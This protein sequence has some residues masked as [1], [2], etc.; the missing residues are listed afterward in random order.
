M[1]KQLNFNDY[2]NCAAITSQNSLSGNAN[3]F[4]S[5]K[6]RF[7]SFAFFGFS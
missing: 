1:S 7:A 5:M 6:F 2:A 4:Q 3:L